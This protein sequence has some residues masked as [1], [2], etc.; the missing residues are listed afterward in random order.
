MGIRERIYAM[1]FPVYRRILIK[2][3]SEYR[4]ALPFVLEEYCDECSR[5]KSISEMA[6]AKGIV[7][8]RRDNHWGFTGHIVCKRCAPEWIR[9]T[10]PQVIKEEG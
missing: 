8:R 3:V 6:L 7:Y 2:S 10:I 1:I 9:K 5:I 4:R